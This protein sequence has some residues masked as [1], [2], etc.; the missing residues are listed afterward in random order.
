[1]GGAAPQRAR[2]ANEWSHSILHL[3]WGVLEI[4]FLGAI[5]C[6]GGWVQFFYLLFALLSFQLLPQPS[7]S[8]CRSGARPRVSG[9]GSR[10]STRTVL[11]SGFLPRKCQAEE[12]V[13]K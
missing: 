3:F 11:R 9:R 4:G 13:L 1:M 8:G 7:L 10:V 5:A 12:L 6:N 2:A